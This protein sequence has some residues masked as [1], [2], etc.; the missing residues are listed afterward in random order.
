MRKIDVRQ[1]EEKKLRVVAYARVSTGYAE[2]ISS[3]ENQV[4]MFM[5]RIKSTPEWDFAGVYADPAMTGTTDERPEFQRMLRDAER[6]KFDMILCK[7][8]SRFARNTIITIQT[9]RHLQSIGVAVIFEKE[10][11]DTSKP[12]SEM[13]LTVLSAFAQ[14]ESRNI[15][16]RV[17]AGYRLRYLNGE[18]LWSELYG[19]RKVGKVEYV[20]EEEEA[21]VVRRIFNAYDKGKSVRKIANEL[22]ADGI[23]SPM[24][25]TWSANRI[26]AFLG[27]ERYVGDVLTNKYYV[28]DHMSHKLLKNNG[29]VEQ[30]LLNNHHTPIIQRELFDRVQTIKELKSSS[31]YPY[32]GFLICPHCG[33]KLVYR[34][35]VLGVKRSAWCCDI[36]EFYVPTKKLERPVLE[37]YREAGRNDCLEMESVEYWWLD[38]LVDSITFGMHEDRDD[39]TVI[40]TWIDGQ[41]TTVPSKFGLMK[42]LIHKARIRERRKKTKSQSQTGQKTVTR[43]AAESEEGAE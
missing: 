37:A 27:N 24:K 1:K 14:E 23:P 42:K 32:E 29:E 43:M 12:N 34:P 19:Y 30:I 41:S 7:S 25:S 15:S 6:H 2:Q 8:I 17:K 35:G 28:K 33:G 31:H 20:I 4:E 5:E 13:M 9:I 11:I 3:Y 22:N 38:E 39:Q 18:A 10:N 36:D 16:E 21:A 26:A 40:V